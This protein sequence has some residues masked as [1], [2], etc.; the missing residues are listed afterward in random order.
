MRI[1]VDLRCV[2]NQIHGIARHGIG[3]IRT[4]S[5]LDAGNE[6]ILLV[7]NNGKEHLGMLP[8][9]FSIVVSDI[10]PYGLSE[11]VFLPIIMKKLNFDIY[12]T[13][14]YTAPVFL[15]KKFLFTIHD[16]IHLIFPDDYSVLHS[17]YYKRIIKPLADKAS[18]IF[19]VSENSKK[20]IIRFFD[21]KERKIIVS[22]NGV[23]EDFKPGDKEESRHSLRKKFGIE[24]RFLLW[25]GNRKRH[26]NLSG[27]IKAFLKV[28]D[29]FND[30]KFVG[31]MN[32]REESKPQD[33]IYF[34][35]V[36]E[37]GDLIAFYRSAELLIFPSLYE[38]FGLPA[39]EAM[40]CGCPVVASNVAS[41]PE[42]CSDAVFYVDPFSVES[43]AEGMVRVLSD[44]NLRR[45]LIKNG[46]ER[47]KNFTW[48]RSAR[49]H[50]KV[51]EEVYEE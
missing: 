42:V 40:A 11:Q 6:Y 41:I 18:R 43:I 14:N 32:E 4:L 34:T 7:N 37:N 48:E 3:I 20:D 39:L 29:K 30:L 8:E 22:Y 51:F 1:L 35:N 19:T 45:K 33:N 21:L 44:D 5:A 15:N 38:G 2:E 24:G 25:V 13:P 31:L 26:K 23:D 12:Y 47:A 27:T 50:L 28:K 49:E 16:L 9:N 17:I 36:R 10:K 46:L